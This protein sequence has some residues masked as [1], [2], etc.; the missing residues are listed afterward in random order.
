MAGPRRLRKE[1]R[2]LD[3]NAV[4]TGHY[5]ERDIFLRHDHYVT[6]PVLRDR[7]AGV[8]IGNRVMD[9]ELPGTCRI[10]RICRFDE[11][12][13]PKGDTAIEPGDLLTV[14]GQP[15]D[16]NVFRE[17]YEDQGT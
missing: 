11:V 7:P 16:L 9:L 6:L 2:F 1:L 8:V 5:A 14:I 10:L 3:L 17:M 12:V 13:V 15:E 4:A